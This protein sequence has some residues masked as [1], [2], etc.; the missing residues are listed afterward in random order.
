MPDTP[1]QEQLDAANEKLAEFEKSFEELK[2]KFEEQDKAKKETPQGQSIA[3]TLAQKASE[4]ASWKGRLATGNVSMEDF[5]TVQTEITDNIALVRGLLDTAKGI[6]DELIG[7]LKDVVE[8]II[9]IIEDLIEL[10]KDLAKAIAGLFED[11]EGEGEVSESDDGESVS[12]RGTSQV[13]MHAGAAL[14]AIGLEGQLGSVSAKWAAEATLMLDRGTVLTYRVT[15][16]RAGASNPSLGESVLGRVRQTLDPIRPSLLHY[17][18]DTKDFHGVMHT[19]LHSS[20]FDREDG[21]VH[22]AGVF[23]GSRVG[24]RFKWRQRSYD[25]VSVTR[26]AKLLSGG[27]S[28]RPVIEVLNAH[29]VPEGVDVA[30]EGSS[31]RVPAGGLALKEVALRLAG[32]DDFETVRRIAEANPMRVDL[33]SLVGGRPAAAPATARPGLAFRPFS[34]AGSSPVDPLDQE[35]AGAMRAIIARGMTA[36]HGATATAE[37]AVVVELVGDA[38]EPDESDSEARHSDVIDV[39]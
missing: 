6:F 5:S 35:L 33:A 3:A 21:P 2:K 36:T 8:L 30:L 1:T 9:E 26:V 20:A 19:V 27:R 34:D 12:L 7:L 32:R 14:A 39:N 29:R 13:E 37:T 10:L 11:S 23:E 16:Y 17:N 25:A 18:T 4:I 24:D 15:R 22:I 38:P 31:L 28:R